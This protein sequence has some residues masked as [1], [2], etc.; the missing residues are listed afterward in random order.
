MIDL[1][2]H[3][4]PGIDDG[5]PDE[6][7]SLEMARIAVADGIRI[8]ACTPHIYPGLYENEAAD[9]KARI[10]ALQRRLLEEGIALNLTIGADAHLTPELLGRL[11]AGTAPSLAG[12]RYF[13][14][15]PPH[16]IAPPRFAESMFDFVAAGYVPVLTHPERLSWIQPHYAVFVALVKSGV[17]MQITSGSLNGRFG[18]AAQYFG[19][20]MLDEGLV[21]ILATDAHST[22]HRAPLLAEGQ[23][24]AEK[25][26]G[27]EEARR[28]VFDRP[29]AIIDNRP[30]KE[31]EP[32]PSMKDGAPEL[33]RRG[34]L[35][36]IL[37]RSRH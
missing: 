31:V 5:A 23:R 18:K 36:R 37:G 4:L 11:K 7:A 12:G 2:C 28:L 17:W 3:M 35:S 15:E 19:E 24:A 9:I 25:F 22:R 13:L 32:V 16:T 8:T 21:H 34:F 33:A 20:K 26:V 1:H 14:L 30:P 6:A 27:A 29:Q 10:N